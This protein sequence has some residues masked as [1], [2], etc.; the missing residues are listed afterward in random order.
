MMRKV[1]Q[2]PFFV[3]SSYAGVL[4][5]QMTDYVD[6]GNQ[7][8]K[9]VAVDH[10]RHPAGVENRQQAPRAAIAEGPFAASSS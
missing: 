9:A 8:V 3:A 6:A 5:P 2:L 4:P 1:A 7:A 10:D